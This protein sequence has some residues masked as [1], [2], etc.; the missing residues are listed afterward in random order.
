MRKVIYA[1]AVTLLTFQGFSSFAGSH[2]SFE[3]S[4]GSESVVSVRHNSFSRPMAPPSVSP[5]PVAVTRTKTVT[6]VTPIYGGYPAAVSM[7]VVPSP[8]SYSTPS[9]TS[10]YYPSYYPGYTTTCYNCIYNGVNTS[11]PYGFNYTVPNSSTITTYPSLIYPPYSNY[12][13]YPSYPSGNS[14]YGYPTYSFQ[15]VSYPQY[16]GGN[17]TY[18]SGTYYAPGSPYSYTSLAYYPARPSPT[19]YGM[20]GSYTGAFGSFYSNGVPGYGGGR[21]Y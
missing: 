19:P 1:G 6:T 11:N 16:S 13:S 8:I 7:P 14:G 15:K 21:P 9:Y 10:T 20:G 5:R 3:N 17:P 12:P 18:F 2:G 4:S